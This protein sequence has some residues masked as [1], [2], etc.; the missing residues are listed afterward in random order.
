MLR[1]TRKD[2]CPRNQERTEAPCAIP[3]LGHESALKNVREAIIPDVKMSVAGSDDN[4][5]AGLSGSET[6]NNRAN[7]MSRIED[8]VRSIGYEASSALQVRQIA[9]APCRGGNF[10]IISANDA[11]ESS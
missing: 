4:K 7:T 1:D 9:D 11:A 3:A 6:R 8:K 10:I 2:T 5:S